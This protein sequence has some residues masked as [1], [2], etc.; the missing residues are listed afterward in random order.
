MA[1]VTKQQ[2]KRFQ[3]QH[4]L[5]DGSVRDEEMSASGIQFGESF[6]WHSIIHHLTERKRAE[7]AGATLS[8]RNKVLLLT[9]SDGIHRRKIALKRR[10]SRN[11]QVFVKQWRRDY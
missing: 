3:F 7:K 2:G 9:G 1:S 8:I 4:R 6:A 10:E 11:V 5:T